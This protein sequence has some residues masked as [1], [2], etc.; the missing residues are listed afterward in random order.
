MFA[1]SKILLTTNTLFLI[2]DSLFVM[3]MRLLCK[4]IFKSVIVHFWG[5]PHFIL[6]SHVTI[7]HCVYS[8]ITIAFDF[9]PYISF[10][11]S[12]KNFW[13]FSA[14][15]FVSLDLSEWNQKIKLIMY[16]INTLV[17]Q[18]NFTTISKKHDQIYILTLTLTKTI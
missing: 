6:I 9:Y 5:R 13:H 11:G 14:F 17:V 15:S 1:L 16:T 10:Q 12:H 8:R 18:W 4:Y 7:C 3:K 2:L